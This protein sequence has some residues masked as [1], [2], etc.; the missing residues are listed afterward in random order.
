[1]VGVSRGTVSIWVRD[2][3]L[4][5]EQ[6][7]GLR[8]R[9][10]AHNGQRVGARV[11]SE[12]AREQRLAWQADGRADARRGD[13]LHVAGC[14]LFWGEGSKIRTQ[15]Q[16]ANSDPEL[17][18]FFLRFLRTCYGVA[19]SRVRI[20]CNLYADQLARQREVERFWLDVLELPPSSLRKSI[21]N[22]YSRSSKRKRRNTLP[23]GTCHLRV[24]S[25]ELAQKIFGAIQEY[26]GFT[27]ETWLDC[28]HGTA[29]PA[30]S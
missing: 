8:A 23:Y 6:H 19:D 27:N 21:V 9:N 10:P 29:P 3:Q 7:D 13:P 16:L 18:R 14:M 12:R 30:R 26:G 5:P 1:M 4:T 17:V 25:T 2:I 28:L 15:V 20:R 11:R 24:H 22:N